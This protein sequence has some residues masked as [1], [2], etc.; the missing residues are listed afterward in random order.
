MEFFFFLKRKNKNEIH[1]LSRFLILC[2][3]SSDFAQ[4]HYCYYLE[5]T[6]CLPTGELELG[7][8][9]WEGRRLSGQPHF[10]PE[11]QQPEG[12]GSQTFPAPKPEP[13]LGLWNVW[14]SWGCLWAK[15]TAERSA[16]SQ[17]GSDGASGAESPLTASHPGQVEATA[18]IP[19][20]GR[21]VLSL[22]GALS[23][24]LNTSLQVKRFGFLFPQGNISANVA[25]CK[26]LSGALSDPTPCLVPTRPP[27]PT[28]KNSRSSKRRS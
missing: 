5:E 20:V 27:A 11:R 3:P 25:S 28:D 15:C 12:A 17:L 4:N 10:T 2:L 22:W 18:H 16:A 19:F 8:S 9:G 13:S 24:Q 6:K 26:K 14:F 23:I 1:A 21:R 7:K